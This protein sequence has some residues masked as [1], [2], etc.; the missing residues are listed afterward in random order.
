MAGEPLWLAVFPGLASVAPVRHRLPS[1]LVASSSLLSP[2]GAAPLRL[3][4]LPGLASGAPVRH[5]L[6]SSLVA[7]SSLLSPG[8]AAPL[9]LAGIPAR[10]ARPALAGHPALP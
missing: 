5:R 3:A 4:V 8:G 6:P 7:S 1:S 2:G 9:R 10:P